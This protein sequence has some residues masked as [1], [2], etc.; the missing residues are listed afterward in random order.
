MARERFQDPKRQEIPL[1]DRREQTF[2][3]V[4]GNELVYRFPA[5]CKMEL[6]DL[7]SKGPNGVDDGGAGDDITCRPMAEIRRYACFFKDERVDLD[8]IRANLDRL[9]N[10]PGTMKIIGVSPDELGFP[11]T[12]SV[13]P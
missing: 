8:W 7:Y 9:E 2:S 5:R 11:G 4:W 12:E 1:T 6:F 10:Y 3:D 13:Q